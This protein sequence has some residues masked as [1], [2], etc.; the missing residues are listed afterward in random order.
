MFRRGIEVVALANR[1]EREQ[2]ANS[3]LGA[4]E[5]AHLLIALLVD[6]LPFGA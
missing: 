1:H 2:P 4:K 5:R 6:G 3:G